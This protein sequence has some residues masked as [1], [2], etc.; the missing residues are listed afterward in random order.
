VALKEAYSAQWICL[1][2]SEEACAAVWAIV[3]VVAAVDCA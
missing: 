1:L 3:I 2:M